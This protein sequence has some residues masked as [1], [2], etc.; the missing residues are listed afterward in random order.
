MAALQLPAISQTQTEDEPEPAS[1]RR[2]V[3]PN[4]TPAEQV[5]FDQ[6]VS[7]DTN[8]SP[9]RAISAYR[10]FIRD[11]PASPLAMKAQYRIAE[12]YEYLGDANKAF[13]NY[14]TLLTQYPD[15]PDFEK[16]VGRQVTI[17]NMYLGGRKLKFLG[18]AIVPST[19]RAEEMFTS[20]I[21]NAPYSKNAPVA[22]FN[23]GLTYERQG[24]VKEAAAAYQAVLD[25]YPNS[26]VAD[27]ALYQIGY[28][29]KRLGDSG[30]SQDLSAVITSK[31]TFED[32]LLQ[33]PNNEKSPQARDNIGV[34]SAK[35]TD[36]LMDIARYYDRF[37]N[38]RAAAIYYND[39]IR[40][41]PGSADANAAEAR[42]QELR[43][44]LGEDALRTGPE[45]AE[46][47]EKAAIRRRL[48]AQVETSA[49]A[50]FNGPPRRDVVSDELPV[51]NKPRLRTGT[52]DVAPMPAVEPVLPAP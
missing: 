19:D 1:Q 8:S 3:N 17:A 16:A 26:A 2:Q 6:A 15:T 9:S 32:F 30:R 41:A 29:Y 21:Q 22:Q 14:Q 39:V 31:N 18:L 49:L 45:Q 23:L 38:Y 24:R 37:K 33:F 43:A 25:N 48:Q 27:D 10:R 52:R 46:T 36:D 35:E 7:I 50:D 13:T 44:E 34:L 28:I 11:N 40:R 12:I 51:V 47:G 4:I 20:I 5:A 42:M